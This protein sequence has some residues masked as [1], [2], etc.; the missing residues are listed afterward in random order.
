MMFAK[1]VRS[2]IDLLRTRRNAFFPRISRNVKLLR[3]MEPTAEFVRTDTESTSMLLKTVSS[4]SCQILT[5]ARKLRPISNS[6]NPAKSNA[7]SANTIT[8]GIPPLEDVN[9]KTVR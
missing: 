4:V 7:D 1:V 5:N 8:N 2:I 3:I 9:S 6:T